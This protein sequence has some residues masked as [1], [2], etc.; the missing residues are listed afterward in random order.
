MSTPL[1]DYKTLKFGAPRFDQ[2]R[3]EHI[4]PTLNTALQTAR[5][6]FETIKADTRAPDFLNTIEA[7]NVSSE[8][9][10]WSAS[11]FFNLLSA[12]TSD[13]WQALAPKVSS[14][15]SQFSS[16][17]NLDQ[18]LFERVKVVYEKYFDKNGPN[19]LAL[20]ELSPEQRQLLR[21]TYLGFSRNGA[22]LPDDKKAEL[23]A[24]DQE[25]AL[26][27]PK[28]DENVLKA[29]NQ[30]FLHLTSDE[31]VAGL[32]P[33]GLEAG[34]AA[35]QE[36]KLYGYVY[37]L[38]APSYIPFMTFANRR[39]LREKL[40]RA[41]SSRAMD[42]D[43]DNRP[44]ATK[45]ADLRRQR[46]QLLGYQSHADYVLQERMAQNS[47]TVAK[48]LED[49]RKTYRPHAEKDVEAIRALAERLDGI[50][51]IKPWDIA[52][53]SE[54]L[55][56]ELFDFDEEQLRPYFQLE[57]VIRGAFLHA[58][59]LYGLSFKKVTEFPVYHPDVQVFEVSDAQGFVGLLYADFFPRESKRGGA[60]MTTFRDQGLWKGK[61]ER[62]LVAI[63]CNFTK[64]VAGKPSLI[65]YDEVSTL[66]HEFGHALHAL[67]SK[68]HYR[69]MSGTN[70]Y[71]DFVELPSQ[72]MEN[73]VQEK[74][75][76]DLFAEHFETGE[77]IP[78]E[79]IDKIK[80]SRTFLSGYAGLRQISLGL[81]DM[82]WATIKDS[83]A[84]NSAFSVDAFEEKAVAPAIV[85]PKIPGTC[86]STSFSHIFAGG[87]SAG[88]YSYK[89][90]E[91]LDADAFE[92]FKEKGLFS[93][94]VAQRFRDEILSRGGSEPPA[95]LYQRFR[96]RNADPMALLRRDGLV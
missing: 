32:P 81:L 34:R 16:D 58:E 82:A 77:K 66:F 83:L 24:L 41:F 88:Y 80:R 64:P 8:D 95:E 56:F 57:K 63:V 55:K 1:L 53:Y 35:A 29:V 86:T 52:F 50:K 78:Q 65:T 13:A 33:S 31:D 26:L 28:F 90:A 21:K 44:V 39:D 46:A 37:T 42:G 12:H 70:V 85:L 75:S 43:I 40:W 9:L 6:N 68:C 19:S 62:P 49:L 89:W 91:V 87:Y 74:E 69:S 92:F 27:S 20:K 25:M 94:D 10:D 93:K 11:Y 45:V 72:I 73:W 2:I 17:V 7:L 84:Q 15:L 5:A 96:G 60:W 76:L 61:V 14:L 36:R 38:H 48:F 4:E 47:T 22:L 51:E 30:F 23:R 54:K 18:K 59:R 3:I 79:L 67:L 71:W